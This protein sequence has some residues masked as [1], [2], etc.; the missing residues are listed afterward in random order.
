MCNCISVGFI[1]FYQTGQILECFQGLHNLYYFLDH[2]LVW[3]LIRDGLDR[4]WK[5]TRDK[6]LPNSVTA[7]RVRVPQGR[8]PGNRESFWEALVQMA[9]SMALTVPLKVFFEPH[10]V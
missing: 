10:I 9:A 1:N 6:V 3:S 5:L 4:R 2:A 7:V 8:G